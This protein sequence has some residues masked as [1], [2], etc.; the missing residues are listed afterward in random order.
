MDTYLKNIKNLSKY[1]LIIGLCI[2]FLGILILSWFFNTEVGKLIGST[3]L[4]LGLTILVV[5]VLISKLNTDIFMDSLDKQF[6][7]ILGIENKKSKL[8][9]D[10]M[11]LLRG[12]GYK[13]LSSFEENNFYYEEDRTK[14]NNMGII[15]K[16]KVKLIAEKENVHYFFKRG[17]PVGNVNDIEILKLTI[18]GDEI[19]PTDKEEFTIKVCPDFNYFIFEKGLEK[20]KEY[21]IYFE[22]K[23]PKTMSDLNYNDKNENKKDWLSIFNNQLTNKCEFIINFPKDFPIN[24]YKFRARRQ[25]ISKLSYEPIKIKKKGKLGK[26]IFQENLDVGDKI[27]FFYEKK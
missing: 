24:D 18:N 2:S 11:N 4:N 23:F 12:G 21:N 15:E 19:S 7:F 9:P 6:R 25:D 5:D 8:L 1:I 10:I 26:S 13:I 27:W 17:T 22:L 16:V 3:F 20:G 14:K